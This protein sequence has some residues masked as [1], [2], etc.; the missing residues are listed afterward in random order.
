VCLNC[1]HI[2]HKP[3]NFTYAFKCYQN[4][5]TS[6]NVKLASLQLGHPVCYSSYKNRVE[7]MFETRLGCIGISQLHITASPLKSLYP[8]DVSTIMLLVWELECCARWHT[9]RPRR[10]VM[11]ATS[12]M[13]RLLTEKPSHR[14]NAGLM[15]RTR[16]IPCNSRSLSQPILYQKVTKLRTNGTMSSYFQP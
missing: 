16:P 4:N 10:H 5:V 7:K 1:Y 12:N 15:S 3:F 13:R 8:A 2:C 11:R 14:S 6:K 9:V